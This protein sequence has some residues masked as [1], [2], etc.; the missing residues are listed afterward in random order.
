MV[1]QNSRSYQTLHFIKILRKAMFF[2]VDHKS[3]YSRN[4]C[5]WQL[6]LSA[7]ISLEMLGSDSVSGNLQ[8]F[9]AHVQASIASM[10]KIFTP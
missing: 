5:S 9:V 1:A 3:E 8:S 10:A 4:I 7:S 2:S 6:N